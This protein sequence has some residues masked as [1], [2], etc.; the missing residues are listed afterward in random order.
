MKIVRPFLTERATG[1]LVFHGSELNSLHQEV[2]KEILPKELGGEQLF[3]NS[4][5]VRAA[6]NMEEDYQELIRIALTL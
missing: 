4:E 5:I 2:S 3:D 1:V 6:K